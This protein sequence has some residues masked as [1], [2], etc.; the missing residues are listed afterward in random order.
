MPTLTDID[1]FISNIIPD[2]TD[3]T[4]ISNQHNK[5][6][7]YLANDNEYSEKHIETFLSGSYA[8]HTN[9]KPKK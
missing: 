4:Y 8:K 3:I 5:I 9:I 1:E 7:D 6:R 2:T